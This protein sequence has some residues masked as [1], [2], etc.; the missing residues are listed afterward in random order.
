[1]RERNVQ[2]SGGMADGA[3]KRKRFPGAGLMSVRMMEKQPSAPK[4]LAFACSPNELKADNAVYYEVPRQQVYGKQRM[5][6]APT[7]AAP[8]YN[9]GATVGYESLP[10]NMWTREQLEEQLRIVK[11]QEVALKSAQQWVSTQRP[12]KRAGGEADLKVPM[13]LAVKMGPAPPHQD[14]LP[15][16]SHRALV[17]M[18][19]QQMRAQY[20]M[21][22]GRDPHKQP[23]PVPVRI[24]NPA[25]MDA[26]RGA[27]E[28]KELS[29]TMII[30]PQAQL[31]R[32]E[33]KLISTDEEDSQRSTLASDGESEFDF[34]AAKRPPQ[35]KRSVHRRSYALSRCESTLSVA[36]DSSE[37]DA[38]Q[39]A[40]ADGQQDFS[41]TMP[42]SLREDYKVFRTSGT[43]SNALRQAYIRRSKLYPKVRGVWFNSTVRRMGWVG[44]AYKKCKRIEKIFSIS[45]HGFEGA[46]QLAIAFRNSQKPAGG[47]ATTTDE[48]ALATETAYSSTASDDFPVVETVEPDRPLTTEDLYSHEKEAPANDAFGQTAADVVGAPSAPALSPQAELSDRTLR[49]EDISDNAEQSARRKAL[50]AL[51]QY[52]S[53]LTSE[54][55]AHRDHLCKGAL[56]LMLTE[57]A[58][59]VDLEVPLPRLNHDECRRGLEYHIEA[60]KACETA[61][62]MLPYV[63]LFGGYICRGI[64]PVDIPFSEVYAFLHA[65]SFCQPLDGSFDA[66]QTAPFVNASEEASLADLIVV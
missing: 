3:A 26:S 14:N 25:A 57:L 10:L 49:L 34:N 58:A 40:H 61:E 44:Q 41:E 45:K 63:A 55:R 42:E 2:F 51:S 7:A 17:D 46:R 24:Y 35:R 29:E 23:V 27:Q 56:N 9:L 30:P 21:Y 60:L 8:A 1:M 11:Q 22:F 38:V 54:Q 64:T 19:M 20:G 43:M 39:G 12:A 16:L 18:H 47:A 28:G 50:E 6:M 4:Q 65:L 52:K 62:D 5:A 48:P 33:T 15:P 53:Q 66:A 36:N 37:W 59:L 31:C 13:P 32:V